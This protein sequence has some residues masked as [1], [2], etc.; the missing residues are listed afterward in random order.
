MRP[1]HLILRF[2]LPNVWRFFPQRKLA[3]LQEFSQTELDSAWQSLYAYEF[4]NDPKLKAELFSHALEEFHHANLFSKLHDSYEK[5]PMDLPVIHREAV[6]TGKNRSEL[7]DFLSYVH[8]G[9]REVNFDFKVYAAAKIDPKIRDLFVKVLKDEEH[10]QGDS[11]AMLMEASG[12]TRS[13][14]RWALWKA[15]GSRVYRQ[16]VGLL[17]AFGKIPLA[18]VL[19]II[20]FSV[21]WL[22]VG[23]IRRRLNSSYSDQLAIAKDQKRVYEAGLLPASETI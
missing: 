4:V 10:H 19:S 1:R 22:A 20:Y 13:E 2:V 17:S 11:L 14:V 5:A 15:S 21:G 9:E 12:G 6:L 7:I 3:A 18:F 8:V 16:Y 23:S